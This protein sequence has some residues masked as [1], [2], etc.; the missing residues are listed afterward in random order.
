MQ[1]IKMTQLVLENSDMR[2]QKHIKNPYQSVTEYLFDTQAVFRY[3]EFINLPLND[4]T[5]RYLE[6][7][8]FIESGKFKG[9]KIHQ[10]SCIDFYE[11]MTI[12]DLINSETYAK[13]ILNE[14]GIEALG[15][16]W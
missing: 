3:A 14:K 1:L 12:Y 5:I 15:F 11:G 7:V 10:G 4:E 13:I 2:K 8:S 6:N 9:V 16:E